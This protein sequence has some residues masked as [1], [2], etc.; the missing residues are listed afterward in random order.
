M[1][2]LEAI[3]HDYKDLGLVIVG[4]NVGEKSPTVKL[5]SAK[6][7]ANPNYATCYGPSR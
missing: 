3:Y 2:G 1:P 7:T 6:P 4:I 5:G